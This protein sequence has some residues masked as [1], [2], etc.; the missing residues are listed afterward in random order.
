[1]SNEYNFGTKTDAIAQIE[2]NMGSE[3]SHKI[4][5]R[6]YDLLWDENKIEYSNGLLRPPTMK[7]QEFF[8]LWARAEE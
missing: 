7:D 3:G 6:V 4:A 2:D 1:M 8:D 5:E